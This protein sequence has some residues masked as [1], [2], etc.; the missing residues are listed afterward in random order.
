MAY[1]RQPYTRKIWVDVD[2]PDKLPSIPEGQEDLCRFDEKNMNR[3][4]DGIEE[5]LTSIE[6]HTHSPEEVGLEYV[7]GSTSIIDIKIDEQV[8]DF[9]R[10]P[11]LENLKPGEDNISTAFGKIK[12]AIADFIEHKKVSNPHEITVSKIGSGTF[13]G[14]VKANATSSA[15]IGNSQ[16]RN[17]KAGTS[18]LTAGI[19]IL[20]TGELYFVYE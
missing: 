12:K 8:P 3:I 2:D 18:D 11:K 7:E 19:S 15:N 1:T 16:V 4:E 13:A 10:A 9:E 17:I 20:E 14:E 5:A 6:E